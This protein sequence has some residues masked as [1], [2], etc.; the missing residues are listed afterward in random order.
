[1][2]AAPLAVVRRR[3]RRGPPAT[4]GGLVVTPIVLE[5]LAAGAAGPGCWLTAAK[6]PVAVA[7]AGPDGRRVLRLPDAADG[8][9]EEAS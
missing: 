5:E 2:A 4:A 7:V 8:D 9:L 1:M 3:I 6:R